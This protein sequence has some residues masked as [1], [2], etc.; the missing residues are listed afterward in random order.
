KF[1]PATF[2]LAL[3]VKDAQLHLVTRRWSVFGIL[4]PLA[5]SPNASTYEYEEDGKFCFYVE[6]SHW[7]TGLIVRYEGALSLVE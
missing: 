3:V 5:L 4:M 2:W 6:V 1:G 7:L